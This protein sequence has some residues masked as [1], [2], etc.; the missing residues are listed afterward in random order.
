[1]GKLQQ[2][3]GGGMETVGGFSTLFDEPG[4]DLI[5]GNSD[6]PARFYFSS[7]EAG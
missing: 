2:L 1:M 4:A 7:F 6:D 5:L 3:V